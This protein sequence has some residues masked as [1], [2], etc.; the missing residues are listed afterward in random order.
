MIAKNASQHCRLQMWQSVELVH[1]AAHAKGQAAKTAVDPL[2]ISWVYKGYNAE[3][4]VFLVWMVLAEPFPH[5]V[6]PAAWFQPLRH[7]VISTQFHAFGGHLS[8]R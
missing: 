4:L 2:P 5:V 6:R 8:C 3:P 7:L 1:D